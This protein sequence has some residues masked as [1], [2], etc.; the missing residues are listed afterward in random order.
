MYILSPV[1][2]TQFLSSAVISQSSQDVHI[3]SL[4]TSLKIS[5]ATVHLLSE[6]SGHILYHSMDTSSHNSQQYKQPY[7]LTCFCPNS[8]MH[9]RASGQTA[10]C[11]HVLLSKQPYALT[12]FCPNSPSSTVNLRPS[13]PLLAYLYITGNVAG[14]PVHNR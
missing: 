11:T 8:H 12:C 2:H 14:L 7:A 4:K 10:I 9:S 6:I 13:I 1:R 3:L 5:M